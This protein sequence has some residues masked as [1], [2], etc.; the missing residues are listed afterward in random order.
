MIKKIIVTIACC[1]VIAPLA[2]A[3]DTKNKKHTTGYLEQGVT[4]TG[5][6]I[7]TI[8]AGAAA[9]YQPSGMLVVNYTGPGRYILENRASVLSSNGEVARLPVR[10]GTPVRVYFTNIDGVKTI[11]RVVLD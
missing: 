1:A 2:F 10:P 9:S 8:Q 3:K 11:D 5:A 4:V 7:T 6:S